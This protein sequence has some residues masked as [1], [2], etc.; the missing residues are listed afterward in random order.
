[1]Y[2]LARLVSRCILALVVT[3][4]IR[5]LL[6]R[7]HGP[8]MEPTLTD[9]DVLLTAPACRS[10]LRRGMLVVL[11]DPEDPDHL[12][13]KRLIRVAGDCVEARGDNPSWSTDSRRWGAVPRA[14]VTRV[15]ICRLPDNLGRQRSTR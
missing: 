10:R 1:M 14:S 8:S 11:R 9:G 12:V 7:V 2:S 5:L 6:V 13:I 3:S 15:V 4:G